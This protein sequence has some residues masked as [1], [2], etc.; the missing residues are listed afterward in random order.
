MSQDVSD[1]SSALESAY[2][3]ITDCL[4]ARD[5]PFCGGNC[6]TAE[7]SLPAQVGDLFP[8][9]SQFQ[10]VVV[11]GAGHALNLVRIIPAPTIIDGANHE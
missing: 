9:S 3:Q 1:Q 6:E 7:P 11:P 2:W 10:A 5:L 4:P 8:S